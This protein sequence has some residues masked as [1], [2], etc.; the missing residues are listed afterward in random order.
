[1]KPRIGWC[2]LAALL[3]LAAPALAQTE[4]IRLIDGSTLEGRVVEC[5]KD[6][7][8]F[9]Y[10]AKEGKVVATFGAHD[11]DPLCFFE[12]RSSF[13]MDDAAGCL[14][15]AV[16]ALDHELYPQ[17]R[18]AYEQAK[19]LDPVM[20][21]KF[22]EEKGETL[23]IE[24]TDKLLARARHAFD[25]GN[26]ESAEADARILLT[27]FPLSPAASEAKTLMQA[28][29]DKKANAAAAGMA[30]KEIPLPEAVM[31]RDGRRLEGEILGSTDDSVTLKFNYAGSVATTTLSAANL[32]PRSFY[33]IR[34]ATMEDDAKSH[35]ALARFAAENG[36][37]TRA[38]VHFHR[39]KQ[40]DPTYVEELERTVV[41]EVREQI[42]QKM[43][44]D[45][46]KALDKGDLLEARHQLSDL[47]ALLPD[48]KAA[49]DARTI[50]DEIITRAI[51]DVRSK[52]AQA[53]KDAAAGDAA[54]SAEAQKEATEIVEPAM[55]LVERGRQ[56]ESRAL[57]ESKQSQALDMFD[58]A[59]SSFER[60][61]A[62]IANLRKANAE[63]PAVVATIDA[64]DRQLVDEIVE[65]HVHKGGVYLGRGSHNNALAEARAAL[66]VDPGSS[67]A[68]SF[69]ARV[70][71]AAASE[72]FGKWGRPGRPVI[73]RR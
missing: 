20:T 69:R 33:E 59:I 26:L 56:L 65:A 64:L 67:Y 37:Y 51:A 10:T 73:R 61:R 32:D 4:Q 27:I 71:A 30:G 35:V 38:S 66:T 13:V 58:A 11:L 63:K 7:V 22:M 45:A 48:S 49:A 12:I 60:A 21:E 5:T 19:R 44:D 42:A 31:L 41:P 8:G 1:M 2:A 15:L 18:F 28:I 9:E 57:V 43:L 40:L 29:L 14:D 53:A 6:S 25:A 62:E 17:A 72:G 46:K 68:M 36:M 70:E 39:A 47:L 23:A 52:V 24:A 16:F 54:A 55:K 50:V 3:V 34:S